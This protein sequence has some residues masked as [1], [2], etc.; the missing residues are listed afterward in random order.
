MEQSKLQDQ[1]KDDFCPNSQKDQKSKVSDL[2]PS[3]LFRKGKPKQPF[4]TNAQDIA[5]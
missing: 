5:L 1:R 4:G 2:A 3:Y